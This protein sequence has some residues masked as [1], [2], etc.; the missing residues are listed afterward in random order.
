ME[1]NKLKTRHTKAKKILLTLC[2][3]VL[4]IMTA[5]VLLISRYLVNYAIGR[6]GDGGDRN[7]SLGVTDPGDGIKKL[8][9][10]N[11][12]LQDARNKEFLA[13]HPCCPAFLRCRISGAYTGSTRLRRQ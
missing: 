1:D 11:R 5:A 6:D 2:I 10:E 12:A 3:A 9:A 4:I 7:V 8:I 13:Q